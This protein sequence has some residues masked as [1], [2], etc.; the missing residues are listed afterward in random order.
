MQVEIWSDVVCP[1]CAIG[2]RRFESALARFPHRDEVT[3]RWRSFELDPTAPQQ[4]E[5]TLVE[6]LAGKYGT[7]VEKAREMIGGMTATAAEEGWEF[8]LEDA[9]GGNTVDAHRLIHLAHDRGIQDAVK[10]RL[11]SAYVSEREDIGDHDTLARLAAEAGL[12][13]AE[14][15]EVLGSDRYLDAV[16]ADEQQARAYGINGVPFFVV[17][18][19]YGV[20]GAQPADQLLQVLQTAWA[21]SHPLQVLTPARSADGATCTDGSCAV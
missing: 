17:D 8:H 13:E 1:W 4:R 18:A 12:D 11:V 16:R 14:A 5:G 2:K 10:E 3:V 9:R 15:R 21:E 20:S 19:T 7:S 6:H